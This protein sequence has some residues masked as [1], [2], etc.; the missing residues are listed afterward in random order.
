MATARKLF[1][2]HY[3]P[4]IPKDLGF[5]D[6]RLLETLHQQS[7][8]AND[9]GISCFLFWHY[10]FSGKTVL[11][12]P[13]KLWA[14]SEGPNTPFAF[15]WANQS[16][17]GHWHGAPRKLLINQEYPPGDYERHFRH[18]LPY[19]QNSKYFKVQNMPLLYIFRPEDLPN[20]AE[21][22]DTWQSLA[23]KNGLGKLYLIAE[24]TDP[25]GRLTYSSHLK[26]GFDAGVD[27][28]LP[29]ARSVLSEFSNRILGKI[30]LPRIF[31]Y[32]TSL[33]P[34]MS[35]KVPGK[36]HRALIPNWDN[37]PRSGKHGIVI[38]NSSPELFRARLKNSLREIE[39]DSDLNGLLF[40][41]SW[42]EWAEGNHLEP[43]LK[44][45]SSFLD[46]IKEELKVYLD[47]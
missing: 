37:T 10:W 4:Q 46:V 21:F 31:K 7:E 25:F 15:A 42:N 34:K 19:F 1:P 35:H 6:L 9:A 12:H 36:I 45:G 41:K 28:R 16:W 43:D 20:P 24:V 27:M 29:I 33:E 26:D 47:N 18:L 38:R 30:G 40:I 8:I 32:A 13:V 22:V 17:T 44:Y 23:R 3:Q 39:N 14:S 11:D 5:Y 2:G